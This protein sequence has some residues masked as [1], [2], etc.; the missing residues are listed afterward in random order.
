[1]SETNRLKVKNGLKGF[2]PQTVNFSALKKTEDDNKIEDFDVGDEGRS[3]ESVENSIDFEKLLLKL[4]CNLE[5]E[6]KLILVY[7]VLRD[8]GY[9]IDHGSFANTLGIS[10]VKYMKMLKVVK[11][12]SILLVDGQSMLS[13]MYKS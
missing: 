5:I 13:K 8:Y 6:E 4:L 10:R 12:K 1:M 2:I 9:Q 7:Q 11:M 3:V